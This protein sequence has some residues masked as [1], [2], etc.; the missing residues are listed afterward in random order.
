MGTNW[1]YNIQ[2]ALS[3]FMAEITRF[4]NPNG[5]LNIGGDGELNNFYEGQQLGEIWGY[6]TVGIFQSQD[7]V[8]N[9]P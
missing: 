9:A 3:D 6:E 4:N 5:E 2:V 7:E 1:G 8:D